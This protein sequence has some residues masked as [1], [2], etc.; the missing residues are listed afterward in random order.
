MWAG[1][2]GRPSLQAPARTLL[3][4]A[5]PHGGQQHLP[6]CAAKGLHISRHSIKHPRVANAVHDTIQQEGKDGRN[7][8]QDRNLRQTRGHHLMWAGDVVS[9]SF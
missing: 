7:L 5:P 6:V 9:P 8:I 3:H 2:V 4:S 1:D